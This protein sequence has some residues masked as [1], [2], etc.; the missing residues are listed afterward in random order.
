MESDSG[1]VLDPLCPIIVNALFDP[2]GTWST[3]I[4]QYRPA[5]LCC[6]LL[7]FERKSIPIVAW[8]MLS[9]ESY[10]NRVIRDVLPT[11]YS[12]QHLQNSSIDAAYRF[13]RRGRL[14]CLTVSKLSRAY[15]V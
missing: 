14:I 7:T 12:N 10:I 5:R 11:V 8:Y 2:R 13:A 1:T 6:A 3:Q 9:K 4:C 15:E